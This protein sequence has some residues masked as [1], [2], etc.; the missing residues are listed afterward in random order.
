MK[1]LSVDLY[2][3][4]V[5]GLP[6]ARVHS[7]TTV[8]TH[9]Y[10]VTSEFSPLFFFNPKWRYIKLIIKGNSNAKHHLLHKHGRVK[11]KPIHRF[12]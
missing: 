7:K 12:L 11:L 9:D 10:L 6:Y 3:S 8:I 4:Q 2:I 1:C 5:A